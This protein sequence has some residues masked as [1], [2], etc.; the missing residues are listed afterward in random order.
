MLLLKLRWFQC[1]DFNRTEFDSNFFLVRGLL[2]NILP[3][4]LLKTENRKYIS[5]QRNA[6]KIK[7]RGSFPVYQNSIDNGSFRTQCYIPY[8]CLKN[9]DC[10]NA[11]KTVR[12]GDFSQRKTALQFHSA[13]FVQ[14]ENRLFSTQHLIFLTTR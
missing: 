2:E 6:L 1:R 11:E 8:S 10:S 9:L 13:P 14:K 12:V 5:S 7:N 4:V 3:F